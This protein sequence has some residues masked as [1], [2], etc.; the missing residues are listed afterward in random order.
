MPNFSSSVDA[1]KTPRV[2]PDDRESEYEEAK[3]AYTTALFRLVGAD[4][5]DLSDSKVAELFRGHK[6]KVGGGIFE[7][8]SI[9][10][11]SII[12]ADVTEAKV[13][14]VSSKIPEH[15]VEEGY[16][17]SDESINQ[18]MKVNIEGRI[19]GS[20]AGGKITP[21]DDYQNQNR[22]ELK[23]S[24]FKSLVENNE[25][26][27]LSGADGIIDGLRCERIERRERSASG[28]FAF[29][30]DLK[31]VNTV[32]SKQVEVPREV[33]IREVKDSA[34]TKKDKGKTSPS[35]VEEE[36]VEVTK[37]EAFLTVI[38]EAISGSDIGASRKDI[39]DESKEKA[40]KIRENSSSEM[41]PD[42]Y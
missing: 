12:Y 36:D 29:S 25:K 37:S 26:I 38:S 21:F 32:S 30:A 8:D 15:P 39:I 13:V 33:L 16:K 35:N 22:V 2:H 40:R 3:K 42:R 11:S 10:S 23:W 27:S 17:V 1:P 24:A 9:L 41:I 4:D 6:F 5:E 28:G 7:E 34:Q 14:T 31:R 20:I 18:P 19:V